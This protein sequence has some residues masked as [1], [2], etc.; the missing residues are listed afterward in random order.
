MAILKAVLY[1]VAL[2]FL[3]GGGLCAATAAFIP[4]DGMGEIAVVALVVMA[5]SFVVMKWV[6]RPRFSAGSPGETVVIILLFL[7]FVMPAVQG[8]AYGVGSG[9][10][11][12]PFAPL[13]SLAALGAVV[14]FVVRRYKRLAAA[15]DDRQA[16]PP[17]A[18]PQA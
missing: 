13:F 7:F 9:L 10:G 14:Y 11:L 16:P 8:L 17:E 6:G 12:G 4:M 3:V 2:L 1:A 18:P 15:R 5:I